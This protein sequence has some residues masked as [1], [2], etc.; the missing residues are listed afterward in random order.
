[1]VPDFTAALPLLHLLGKAHPDY[2]WQSPSKC[3]YGVPYALAAHPGMTERWDG[4]A[5]QP[6]DAAVPP[7]PP[8]LEELDFPFVLQKA[9]RVLCEALSAEE[10]IFN[11][12]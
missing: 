6:Q 1:M 11:L 10:P 9:L 2:R 5:E 7:P 12:S 3:P 8:D 4:T